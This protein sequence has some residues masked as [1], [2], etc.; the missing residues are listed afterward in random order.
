MRKRILIGTCILLIGI[1]AACSNAKELEDNELMISNFALNDT[2]N[3]KKNAMVI[4]E[5][6]PNLFVKFDSLINDSRCPKNADCI[7][8]GDAEIAIDVTYKKELEQITLHTSNK[9]GTSSEIFGY[10]LELLELTPYPGDEA[11]AND[12]VIAKIKVIKL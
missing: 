5:S 4:C 8:A 7:W 9:M 1:V 10:K 3:L 2:V 6:D 12:P 11:H